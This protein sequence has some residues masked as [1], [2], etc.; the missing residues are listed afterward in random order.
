MDELITTMKKNNIIYLSSENPVAELNVRGIPLKIHGLPYS[1]LFVGPPA[2]MR[3]R[4]QDTWGDVHVPYDILLS[5]SFCLILRHGDIPIETTGARTRDCDHFLSIIQRV[6]PAAAFFG[7]IHEAR[8]EDE[9]EWE[10]GKIT[11]L[12]NVAVMSKD[13]T[14]SSPIIFDIN[15][16]NQ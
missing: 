14:L 16:P 6:R 5:I 15:K 10:D 7:H 8:G 13:Q 4:D 12:Y 2:F 9:I 1:P 3:P 11:R